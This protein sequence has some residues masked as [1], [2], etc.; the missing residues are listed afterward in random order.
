MFS[1]MHLAALTFGKMST[2]HNSQQALKSNKF[3]RTTNKR[4]PPLLNFKCYWLFFSLYDLF[5]TCFSLNTFSF[6]CL[7]LVLLFYSFF[8]L[9][10]SIVFLFIWWQWAKLSFSSLWSLQSELSSVLWTKTNLFKKYYSVNECFLVGRVCTV[11]G[12]NFAIPALIISLQ[13][14]F[15]PRSAR[16][17]F[18]LKLLPNW[19]GCKYNDTIISFQVW[20]KD[21]V[22]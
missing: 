10:A 4:F 13:C 22:N 1:E 14:I 7:N 12:S 11:F 17:T 8:S 19:L 5:H 20:Y 3:I 15:D 18:P 9:S 6:T 2:L 21:S 16:E